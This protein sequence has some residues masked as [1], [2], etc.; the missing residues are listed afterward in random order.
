MCLLSIHFWE[1][2]K[3]SLGAPGLKPT[4]HDLI[5][6]KHEPLPGSTTFVGGTAGRHRSCRRAV[7]DWKKLRNK[8]KEEETYSFFMF[9]VG[10]VR[11]KRRKT[12]EE[13]VFKMKSLQAPGPREEFF[14]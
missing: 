12:A 14:G 4:G 6:L 2:D 7:D 11:D 8:T 10:Q 9:F 5:E 13:A 3:I 1:V